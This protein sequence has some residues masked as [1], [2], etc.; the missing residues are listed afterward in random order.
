M[1]VR[2]HTLLPRGDDNMRVFINPGHGGKDPGAVGNGLREKDIVLKIARKMVDQLKIYDVEVKM[3]RSDDTYYT[4]E[5]ICNEAN[6]WNADLFVSIHVNAGGGTGFESY[7]YSGLS[8]NSTTAKHRQVIHEEIMKKIPNVRDR[9]KKKANF[10]V[11]GNT[12]MPAILTENL[13]IDNKTDATKLKSDAFLTDVA[14]GHVN[15][16]VKALKLQ[17]KQT[18]KDVPKSSTSNKKNVYY[19]VVTGSFTNRSNAEKRV[20]E[21]KKAGYDSF[22]ERFEK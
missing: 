22:I 2:F 15:G 6:R 9:G 13:F 3:F 1:V 5:Q 10:Y 21:L 20:A 8:N 7:I 14:T 18:Q 19:R 16:I 4:L 11:L 17:K 12:K